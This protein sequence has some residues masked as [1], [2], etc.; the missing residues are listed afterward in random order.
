MK[1]FFNCK[2]HGKSSLRMNMTSYFVQSYVYIEI[3]FLPTLANAVLIT[4]Q[5][6]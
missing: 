3:H 6:I 2:G 5:I 1:F 4:H